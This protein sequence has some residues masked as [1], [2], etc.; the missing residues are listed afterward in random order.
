[1]ERRLELSRLGIW[2]EEEP[3]KET[4]KQQQVLEVK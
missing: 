2:E 3:A 1:M 4:K